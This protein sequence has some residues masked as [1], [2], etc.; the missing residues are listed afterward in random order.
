MNRRSPTTFGIR[1]PR[2]LEGD[3]KKLETESAGVDVV[4]APE[5]ADMYPKNPRAIVVVL[6]M[7]GCFNAVEVSE[8]FR[9]PAQRNG[10]A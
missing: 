10:R 7:L 1:Y 4:F 5:P 3:L 2:D 6:G 8:L 9:F